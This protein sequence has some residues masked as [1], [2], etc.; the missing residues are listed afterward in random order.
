MD[1]NDGRVPTPEDARTSDDA[2]APGARGTPGF[3]PVPD[4]AEPG[5]A[6]AGRR[7]RATV[8]A[9]TALAL[10]LFAGGSVWAA[11]AG[12]GT[13]STTT[14]GQGTTSSRTMDRPQGDGFDQGSGETTIPNTT[15][16]NTSTATTTTAATAA[17]QVGLVTIVT[18][19]GYQ[20]A[21]AAGTGIVL[22]SDG[23][24]LTNN[25]VI[26]GATK[27]AV[28]V[29]STGKTYAAKVVGTDA[30]ADVAV[31]RLQ[32]ASGLA[33]AP[34]DQDT[35]SVGDAVTAVGNAEGGGDLLA[36][37]GTVTALDQPVTTRSDGVSAGE[38]LTGL[39]ELNA[40]VVSG[41]SGGAV[42]DAQGDVLGMTTAASSGS[43]DIT[44]YAIPIAD[45]LKVADGIVAGVD[46][47]SVTIGYPGFLG[48]QIVPA[49]VAEAAD[50]ATSGLAATGQATTGA[51]VGGVISGTPAADAG[52][53]VGDTITA[54][55]GVAVTSADSL[56]ALLANHAPGDKVTITAAAAAA[57]T[58]QSRSAT[59]T[60]I[61]GPAD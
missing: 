60:L 21:Q 14:S 40:D 27:L 12:S 23:E 6:V 43:A 30:T 51:V 36:A 53:A 19:L 17:Q 8:A 5:R 37:G 2:G 58:G 38:T 34:I 4:L 10:G 25:H 15:I 54:L 7:R 31:L 56:S 57:A 48:V 18:T 28:T 47:A 45:A 1:T 32:G 24:I 11:R 59:V 39:I 20:A 3:G 33:T 13:G 29:E 44:G 22:T 16:P 61:A 35:V 26:E 41:D 46:S 9:G 50:L 42:L 55:D 49:G 52:L